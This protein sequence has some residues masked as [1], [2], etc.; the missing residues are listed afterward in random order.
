V[1]GHRTEVTLFDAAIESAMVFNWVAAECAVTGHLLDGLAGFATTDEL[2]ARFGFHPEKRSALDALLRVLV[3]LGLVE[4]RTVGKLPCVYRARPDAVEQRRALSGG[5]ESYRPRLER[6]DPWYGDRHVDLI[7]SSNQ[8]L[9]GDDLAFFRNP[10]TR[11]RFERQYFPAWRTN[12]LNPLY[13]FG[14]LLA[15]RELVGRGRRF[16]DLACGMGHGA[17]RIAELAAPE[18][19]VVCVD[20]SEDMLDEA[21]RQDYRGASV[22]FVR[23]DLNDGLPWLPAGWFDGVLFNGAFHFIQNKRARLAEI[24]RVLRPGGLLV[25]GHCFCR[26]NFDDEPM[27]DL[28]FS[29][30]E[31]Q[32]WIVTFEELRELVAETGFVEL[33]QYHRGSHS[34][35]LAERVPGGG[36]SAHDYL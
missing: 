3:S 15:V 13:E 29:L 31:N 8:R 11:I 23:R 30:V 4:Q 9:L 20:I 33:R 6:L 36:L 22:R 28:Y 14:R 18:S 1:N 12:L 25:L 17:Q 19:E 32:S 26:N 24:H 27:H 7:R 16:L 2:I 5:I 34:Y 10:A 21:R 35:L